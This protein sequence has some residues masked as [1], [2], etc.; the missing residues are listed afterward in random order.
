MTPRTRGFLIAG[1][2]VLALGAGGGWYWTTQ[3]N[4]PAETAVAQIQTA[5]VTTQDFQITVEGP[6]SLQASNTY[7]VKSNVSGKVQQLKNVGD[8][9]VRGQL[10]ARIDPTQYQQA[11]TDAQ[12]SLQKA[13]L[14]LDTLK[15]NQSSTILSQQQSITSAQISYDNALSDY[16]T[17]AAALKANQTIY[18]A[19]GISAQALQ[20]SKNAV[21]KAES[22]LSNAKLTLAS[23]RENL[24][25]KSTTGQQD[26]RSA[27][28]AVDQARLSIKTAQDNLA[29]TKIFAPISGVISTLDSPDGTMVS[30]NSG[31]L[32]L[33]DDSKVKVPVQVDE[34]EI[35]K[36]KVGQRVEVTLDALPD[37][38]F[39]GKVTQVDPSATISNNIAVFNAT[40]TLENPDRVLRP[41]MSAESTI[42][43]LEVPGAMMVPKTA[44]DTVRRRSYV[45]VQKED[46]SIEAVRVTTGP[47]DG[48]NVVIESGLEPGQNV[49]LPT[50]ASAAGGQNGQGGQNRQNTGNNFRGGAGFGIPLGG[51][52]GGGR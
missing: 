8:R 18:N 29:Q 28:L 13:Q 6:G 22:A 49:V 43:T 11:V 40:V 41:G 24:S 1:G 38:T 9:V 19:G 5:Q 47:D 51:G 31:V 36:V 46:G 44:V 50:T 34:T 21:Q 10:I 4:K 45:N 25:T 32:T 16:N 14:Q 17:A 3:K 27:Q 42:I 2:V 33:Q 30:A 48:S 20:D 35:S 7:A 52:F 23:A 15:T 12:I 37:Q 39:E 26:I